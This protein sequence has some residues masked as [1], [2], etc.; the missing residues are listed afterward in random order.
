MLN[1][2]SSISPLEKTVDLVS[3]FF[4]GYRKSDV[5]KDI[6]DAYHI[7]EGTY[8]GSAPKTP[9]GEAD[10]ESLLSQ[11]SNFYYTYEHTPCELNKHSNPP[12]LCPSLLHVSN[13]EKFLTETGLYKEMVGIIHTSVKYVNECEM[14]KI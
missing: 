14:P 1:S 11:V 10:I 5:A 9:C 7:Y 12:P 4:K 2:T 6:M 8:T 13:T 3:G